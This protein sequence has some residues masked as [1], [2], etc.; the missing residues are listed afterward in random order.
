MPTVRPRITVD[1]A[2]WE[3]F[4]AHCRSLR[5]FTTAEALDRANR[6]IADLHDKINVI[7]DYIAD[8]ESMPIEAMM[9]DAEPDKVDAI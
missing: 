2:F 6:Q 7:A 1:E 4:V 5:E 3:T 9:A 8:R